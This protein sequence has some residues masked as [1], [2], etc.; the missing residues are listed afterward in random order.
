MC[1]LLRPS[2]RAK[3]ALMVTPTNHRRINSTQSQ[4]F[5]TNALA[6]LQGTAHC[7]ITIVIIAFT[8]TVSL[9]REQFLPNVKETHF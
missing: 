2:D 4:I 5:H 1:C 9:N 3:A 8:G 6:D 7:C